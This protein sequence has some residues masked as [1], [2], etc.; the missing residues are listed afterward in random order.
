MAFS[1][2]LS[3][4]AAS[5]AATISGIFSKQASQ[6]ARLFAPMI[7]PVTAS[8]F[9]PSPTRISLPQHRQKEG[10]FL[11]TALAH[12]N[13]Q[14]KVISTLVR[15]TLNFLPQ[16]WHVFSTWALIVPAHPTEQNFLLFVGFPHFS[17]ALFGM[18]PPNEQVNHLPLAYAEVFCYS[19]D[20]GVRF[21]RDSRVQRLSRVITYHRPAFSRVHTFILPHN[22]G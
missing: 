4:L 15:P 20:L 5:L 6:V 21:L 22:K 8:L 14:Q 1:L 17:Q 9:H 18:L 16:C 7:F 10:F 2:A 11:F 13:E 3:F 19:H 12:S